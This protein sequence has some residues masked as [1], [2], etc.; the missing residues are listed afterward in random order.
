LKTFLGRVE[1]S[2]FVARPTSAQD[3]RCL[4]QYLLTNKTQNREIP[5]LGEELLAAERDKV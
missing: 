5:H 4:A 3:N 1:P 2:P